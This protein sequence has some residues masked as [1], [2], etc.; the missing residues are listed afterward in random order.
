M[1]KLF[2]CNVRFAATESGRLVNSGLP[3]ETVNRR[4]TEIANLKWNRDRLTI[5]WE[6]MRQRAGQ[7]TLP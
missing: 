5:M 1:S 6:P 4:G 7:K 3:G 2:R